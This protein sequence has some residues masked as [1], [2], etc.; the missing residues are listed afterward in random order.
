[1]PKYVITYTLLE[2]NIRAQLSPFSSRSG[3]H[4]VLVEADDMARA[5]EQAHPGP[6]CLKLTVVEVE[7]DK[8]P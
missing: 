7:H 5:V 4:V 6:D 2:S 8:K 3:D 1:M